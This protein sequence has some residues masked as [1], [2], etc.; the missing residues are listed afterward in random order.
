[1]ILLIG[2]SGSH[3]RDCVCLKG[4]LFFI[5]FFKLLGL[6]L[7]GVTRMYCDVELW[8]I[9]PELDNF[10]NWFIQFAF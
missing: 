5:D 7:G 10:F 2:V 3:L 4:T 8:M 9:R 6:G 1:M